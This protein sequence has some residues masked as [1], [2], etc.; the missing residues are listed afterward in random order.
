MKDGRVLLFWDEVTAADRAA[1]TSQRWGTN[2]SARLRRA[3]GFLCGGS[4][5]AHLR[6]KP[7]LKGE[8]PALGGRR[9]SFPTLQRSRRLCQ[10]PRPQ[11][12]E[13]GKRAHVAWART[14]EGRVKPIPSYSSGGGSGE[15]LLLESRLP[16]NSRSIKGHGGSVSRRDHNS[17]YKR[18]RPRCMGANLR[19]KSQAYSQPLFGRGGLGERRFS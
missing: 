16:R 4:H 13:T 3:E 11:L 1:A 6:A 19:R 17:Q 7:P 5:L 9:G 12:A 14:F 18:T 8:V 15:G 2:P 10:P